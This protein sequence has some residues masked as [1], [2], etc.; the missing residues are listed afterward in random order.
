MACVFAY[1]D[2]DDRSKIADMIGEWTAAFED[3]RVF[4]SDDVR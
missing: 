4:G 3:F 1:W 2:S